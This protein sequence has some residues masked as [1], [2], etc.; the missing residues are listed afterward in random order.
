MKKH[1]ALAAIVAWMSF[2]ASVVR[3]AEQTWTGKISDSLCGMS[4]DGMRKKGDKV[5]DRECTIACVNYQTP[6]APRFVF[7]TGGKVYPIK[8]QSFSG[9]GRRSGAT[10][11]L[12]GDLG[13][14]GEITIAKIEE[15]QRSVK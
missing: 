9:I 1:L 8:N 15:P 6:G 5:T 7:V 2:G 4:H 13:T 14:D 11:V 3:G 10:I 12:T